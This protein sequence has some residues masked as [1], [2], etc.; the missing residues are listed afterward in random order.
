MPAKQRG[1]ELWP[2]QYWQGAL[3]RLGPHSQ[4]HQDPHYLLLWQTYSS[5]VPRAGNQGP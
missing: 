5:N 2:D 4:E 3:A 1:H